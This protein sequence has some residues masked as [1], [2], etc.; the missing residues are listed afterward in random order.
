MVLLLAM[1]YL[2][3]LLRQPTNTKVNISLRHIQKEFDLT[4]HSDWY[5]METQAER[6]MNDEKN[7][8]V[9]IF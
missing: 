4:K 5:I 2:E 9:R 1:M 7:I 6:E 3:V 8:Y